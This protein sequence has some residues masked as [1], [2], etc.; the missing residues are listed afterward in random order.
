MAPPLA[1]ARLV[2]RGAPEEAPQRARGRSRVQRDARPWAHEG[3]L[4][5]QRPALAGAEARRAHEAG[6]PPAVASHLGPEPEPGLGAEAGPGTARQAGVVAARGRLR[7]AR[8]PVPKERDESAPEHPR[9]R[10]PSRSRRRGSCRPNNGRALRQP[11]PW[12]D[13]R[14]TRF[15]TTGKR[16]SRTRPFCFVVLEVRV[17]APIDH[18]DR[19]D[20]RLGVALHFRR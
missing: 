20:L 2:P 7:R 12:R 8:T 10:Q 18:K 17:V 9:G 5:R 14:G 4:V 1:A 19:P 3:P 13:R 15:R 6:Q 11:G 16:R